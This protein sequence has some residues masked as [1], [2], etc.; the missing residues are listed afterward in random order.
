MFQMSL[1]LIPYFVVV[2]L[3]VVFLLIN[4]FHMARFGLQSTKTSLILILYVAGFIFVG[5]VSVLLVFS[6]DWS[7]TFEI[8]NIFKPSLSGQNLLDL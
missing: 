4:L 7:G 2:F 8:Q 3:A 5:I 6:Y 1:L